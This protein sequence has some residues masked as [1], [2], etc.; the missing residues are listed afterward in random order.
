MSNQFRASGNDT[1]ARKRDQK[2]WDACPLWKKCGKAANKKG[3]KSN[4]VR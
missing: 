4:G 1:A 3:G 2:K